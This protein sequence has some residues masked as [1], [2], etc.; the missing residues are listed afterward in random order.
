MKNLFAMLE[1]TAA[2]VPEKTAYC[3]PDMQ[4]SYA[5]LFNQATRVGTC[6]AQKISQGQPVAMLME[7][8][9]ALCV[10]VML[11]V[12]A[13]G[14]FF[15]PLDPNLP[16]E[17]LSLIFK[18]LRPALVIADEKWMEKSSQVCDEPAISSEAALLTAP[19]QALLK[20]RQEKIQP[21]SL[22][23]VLYTS[24]STGIPKGVAHT[25][26]AL[27][28]WTETT[29]AKYGMTEDTVLANQSPWYYANSLLE[30]YVPIKLGA[31]VVMLPP[32]YLSFPKKMIDYLRFEHVTELCM[33]PSGFVAVANAGALTNNLL[34]E[35]T[36]FIMSGEVMP[37]KQ[38][39]MWMDAAPHAQAMNFYGSTETLSVAVDCVKGTDIQGVIPVGRI[40]LGVRLRL[41]RPDGTSAKAGEAGE[42]YVSSPMVTVGYYQDEERTKAALVPDPLK[43]DDAPW[44]K[45]GDY[46]ILDENGALS[47]IGRKDSMIKHHGY[48]MEL[49]EVEEA[50]RSFSGCLEACCLLNEE[51][52]EIWCF[53]SGQINE[54]ALQAHLK[55]RLAKYML[56]E[57]YQILQQMPHNANMKIDRGALNKQMKQ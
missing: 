39:Q 53:A 4:M 8:R 2:R 19:D 35:L 6:V 41:I 33:T 49:G 57:H 40:L 16:N 24:G 21:E 36:M 34:P 55:T 30:L 13:A 17:R 47:V 32:A 25:Q 46:G 23:M 22:A 14:C 15:A 3:A 1:S 50:V 26:Q 18:N 28:C 37:K 48:R 38:L 7:A 43:Q 52:D 56:P 45:T 20:A 54:A 44:F 10:P 9:S 31:R 27:L 42:I 12:L 11:G 51:T 5:Q 29:I